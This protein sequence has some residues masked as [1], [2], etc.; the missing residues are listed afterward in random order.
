MDRVTYSKRWSELDVAG[1]M[2]VVVATIVLPAMQQ[3][4]T[5]SLALTAALSALRLS[6]AQPA[7]HWVLPACTWAVTVL[8]EECSA[9]TTTESR[10][11]LL[12]AIVIAS[13][14]IPATERTRTLTWIWTLCF[15]LLFLA[16]LLLAP[17]LP[18]DAWSR[19]VHGLGYIL[20]AA[21]FLGE[22]AYRHYHF[23]DRKHGSLPALILNIVAVSKEAALSPGQRNA[24]SGRHG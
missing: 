14:A 19:W 8:Q 23:P 10:L 13:R 9:A 1:L 17:V 4:C 20:P 22:Y 3:S 24:E 2:D 21:L 16:A 18:L 11:S 5:G 7:K 6:H 15:M 12:A